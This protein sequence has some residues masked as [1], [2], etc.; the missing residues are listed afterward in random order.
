VIGATF[1]FEDARKA[2]EYATSRDL[3]SKVVIQVA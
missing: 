3:F 2:Y 1:A